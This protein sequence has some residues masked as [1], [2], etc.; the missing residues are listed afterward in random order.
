MKGYGPNNGFGWKLNEV[1][2]AQIVSVPMAVP[3][4]MADQAFRTLIVALAAI[5]AASLLVLNLMLH[6][7]VVRPLKKLAQMA[8]QVSVGNLDMPDLPVHGS[9][10]VAVLAASFNRMR[11][12]LGKA[13]RMLEEE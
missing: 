4:R 5:F 1:V 9:D 11:I 3:V 7:V 12:S 6:F 13:L 8:D 10:E 2:G